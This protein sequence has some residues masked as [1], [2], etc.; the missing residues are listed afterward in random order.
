VVLG[1]KRLVITASEGGRGV[2]GLK[3]TRGESKRFG[4]LKVIL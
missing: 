1:S 2:K 4:Y 3:G